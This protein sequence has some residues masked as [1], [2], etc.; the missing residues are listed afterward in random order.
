LTST[1]EILAHLDEAQRLAAQHTNGPAMII[2]GAGSGKTRVLTYRLAYLIAEKRADPFQ[3][4][5]LTFTNKAAREMKNRI[6]ALIGSEGKNITL[7]TFHSVFLKILKVEG[8]QIGYDN[9]FTVYDDDDSLSLVKSILKERNIDDKKYKPRPV[10]NYI[11]GAK[12]KL[13]GT[14]QYANQYAIDDFTKKVSEVYTI[15]QNRLKLANSMDFDDLLCNTALL[16]KDF[17]TVLAKY[18]KRYRFLMID[19]YQDTNHVQY[20]ITKQLAEQNKNICVVGDDAQSIYSFRGATIENIL[21]FEKD[22][23]DRQLYKLEQNYRSTTTIVGAANNIIANNKHQIPKELYTKN[24]EGEPI[25]VMMGQNEQEEA[26]KVIDTI[27]EVKVY[28]N[29]YNKNIVILYRT[30]AQSRIFEDGLRR[31]SIPYK[32]FGGLSFYKRKEIK[33][34]VAYLRLTTNPQ[35]EE[36]LKRIINYPT[37]GI[38]DTTMA[39]LITYAAQYQVGLWQSLRNAREILPRNASSIHQFVQLIQSFQDYALKATAAETVSYI[40]KT[41]GILK[42]LHLDNSIEG[43]SRYENVQELINAAQEF[44]DNPVQED[45]SLSAFLSEIAL[46]TDQDQQIENDDYISLMTLHAAKGLEFKVVF[47]VGLEENLFPSYFSVQDR[48]GLEEERRLFYV[49]IT[50]AEKLLT[51]SFA[52]NRYRNGFLEPAEPSRFLSEINDEFLRIPPTVLE[53]LPQKAGAVKYTRSLSGTYLKTQ[54]QEIQFIQREPLPNKKLIKIP[55][56]TISNTVE[57]F[58]E[59]PLI[60]GVRVEHHQFGIGTILSVEGKNPDL[61]LQIDF[62]SKGKKT[63]LLKYATLRILN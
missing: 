25:R 5:A 31:A 12:N 34:I 21:N 44:C 8:H 42:E 40:A 51:I 6:E 62:A 53:Y 9:Q 4:L 48:Q 15:Y 3:L 54:N 35:D 32:I 36:A 26:F 11:S 30:N 49:G 2:A 61:R 39:K 17:P 56:S 46:F 14:E 58:N 38:G 41:T 43:L 47:L 13:V 60:E 29:F 52:K 57:N 23:P 50:R 55:K 1:E 18:Q 45:K 20:V 37:R 16:F 10:R 7:G 63:I 19:E 28:H 33:D 27:R 22:Y 24:E 59:T